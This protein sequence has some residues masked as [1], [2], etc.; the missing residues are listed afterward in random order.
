MV[1]RRFWI[2]VFSLTTLVLFV[3]ASLQG[4]STYGTVDGAV[5]DSSGAAI[6]GAQVTLTNTG[7]QEKRTQS[8]GNEGLYQFVN[9]IPG[10]YR[11][12]VEKAGFKHSTR[13]NVAVQ[14]Q[15]DTH[16]NTTM[17]VGEVTETVEVTSEV[18]LL[19]A[20]TSSLGQVVEERKA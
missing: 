15:Q 1:S 2:S 12:D 6:A 14:V 16:V 4:Q 8:S 17:T 9:V 3:C 19:Q 18:P 5:T 20:E 10:N 13:D 11:L 7:T